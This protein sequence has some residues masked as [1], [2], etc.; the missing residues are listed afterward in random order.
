MKLIAR[1]KNTEKQSLTKSRSERGK[2]WSMPLRLSE[3]FQKMG[4]LVL[5]DDIVTTGSTL[6]ACMKVLQDAGYEKISALTLAE[7]E[8]FRH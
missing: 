4:H 7:R 5:V 6:L 2:T 3:Q 1:V 8:S